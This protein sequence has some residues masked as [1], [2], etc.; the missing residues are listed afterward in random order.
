MNNQNIKLNKIYLFFENKAL[1]K[2]VYS[3]QQVK[4]QIEFLKL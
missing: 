2:R 3:E 1:N 4:L